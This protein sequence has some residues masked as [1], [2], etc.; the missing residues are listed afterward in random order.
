MVSGTIIGQAGNVLKENR[1][2]RLI[3]R[4]DQI[5]CSVVADTDPYSRNL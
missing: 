3:I 5:K 4:I 1:K 2:T